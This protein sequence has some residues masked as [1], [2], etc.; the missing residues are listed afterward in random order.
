[1]FEIFNS[2]IDSIKEAKIK[3]SEGSRIPLQDAFKKRRFKQGA[4]K[5]D[6]YAEDISVLG[7]P[8]LVNQ[9][10]AYA[11]AYAASQGIDYITISLCMSI[12]EA[13]GVNVK[14]IIFNKLTFQGQLKAQLAFDKHFVPIEVMQGE[15]V[16]AT[17]ANKR[18][19]TKRVPESFNNRGLIQ[20][21][22]I[23]P[24]FE[25]GVEACI[26]YC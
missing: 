5:S 4:D 21:F 9:V 11:H 19:G 16:P 22:V 3:A 1:M 24:E 20:A 18:A 23:N 25:A 14:E 8:Y 7:V 26:S 6:L 15:V 12:A 2:N 17:P 10:L 13:I